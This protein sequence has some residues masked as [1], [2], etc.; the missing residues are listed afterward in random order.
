MNCTSRRWSK[1]LI[2][3]NATAQ[4]PSGSVRTTAPVPVTGVAPGVSVSWNSKGSPLPS[5][6]SPLTSSPPALMSIVNVCTRER[7]APT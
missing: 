7:L 3:L 5:M 2:D 4:R 6:S 1:S